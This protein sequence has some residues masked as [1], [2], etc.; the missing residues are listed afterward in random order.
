ML[1]YER[2]SQLKRRML[3]PL[4]NGRVQIS[5]AEFSELCDM[6]IAEKP[7]AREIAEAVARVL[8]ERGLV[9]VEDHPRLP[10]VDV[11]RLAGK[12]CLIANVNCVDGGRF[13]DGKAYA[14]ILEALRAAGVAEGGQ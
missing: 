14:E 4:N 10:W 11:E 12:L 7:K 1:T 9:V 8:E 3:A 13:R 6:A 5:P 2:I